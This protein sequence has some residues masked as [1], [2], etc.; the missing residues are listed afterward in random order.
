MPDTAPGEGPPGPGLAAPGCLPWGP[1][2][3]VPAM[4]RGTL[5]GQR[6]PALLAA[7]GP[8][9]ATGGRGFGREGLQLRETKTSFRYKGALTSQGEIATY[10]RKNTA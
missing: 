8:A 3:S 10:V 4:D 5:P 6:T 9:L 2:S 1:A 7:T